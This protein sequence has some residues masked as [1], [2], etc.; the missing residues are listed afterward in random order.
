MSGQGVTIA[1]RGYLSAWR[2]IIVATLLVGCACMASAVPLPAPPAMKSAVGER[3]AVV[4]V[5]EPHLS[6]AERPVFVSYRGWPAERVLD[7]VLGRSWREPGVEVTFR[8]LD[9]YVSRVPNERFRAH[10]AY[11]FF[12]RVDQPVFR[13]DNLL[14]RQ[15]DVPLAPYY[16]VWG[17]IRDTELVADGGTYWPY[18]IVDAEVSHARSA[19]LLP[20]GMAPRFTEVA[21]LAQKYCLSCHQV[22]GYGGD[23]WPVNL[24]QRAKTID[25]SGFL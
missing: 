25:R 13:V 11:L 16:L 15:K 7:R 20:R 18:Q 6:T 8:A 17:N 21:A 10:Q 12:E 22:N 9:G 19:A 4:R 2:K 5:R 3:A 24:A 14:L 23:K 1:L